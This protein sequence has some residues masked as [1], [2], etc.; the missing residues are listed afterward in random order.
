VRQ[1]NSVSGT[2]RQ[3]NPPNSARI[4]QL[5]QSVLHASE[6]PL[7]ADDNTFPG[8][9]IRSR[10]ARA[11]GTCGPASVHRRVGTSLEMKWCFSPR[12]SR[13][14]L[15]LVLI[16]AARSANAQYEACCFDFGCEPVEVGMC[17]DYCGELQPG[18]TCE[19]I[20]G[21]NRA[22]CM[23]DVTCQDVPP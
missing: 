8:A 20:T 9:G 14:A 12:T 11:V 17:V 6:R 4:K 18:G 16:A 19:S 10:S 23:P 22:Y 15:V 1:P 7:C 13:G 2:T 21:P 5:L 3:S